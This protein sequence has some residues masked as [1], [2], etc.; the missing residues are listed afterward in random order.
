MVKPAVKPDQLLLFAH[1]ILPK[2]YQAALH[3]EKQ[4]HA[5]TNARL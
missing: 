1:R 3:R 4:T 2:V 5:Q